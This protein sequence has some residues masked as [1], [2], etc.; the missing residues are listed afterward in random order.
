MI[1]IMTGEDEL[2]KYDNLQ[3]RN[4]QTL[5][6]ISQLQTQEQDLYDKL[7]D[8]TLNTEQKQQIVNTINQIS[9]MR[10]NI[11]ANLKDMYANYQQNVSESRSTLNQEIA[12]IDILENELKQSRQRLKLLEDEKYNKLRLVEINTYYGKRYNSHIKI[13]KIIILT[14]I[15]IIIMSILSNKGILPLNLT[16]FF[17]GIV[18][19]IGLV[20]LGLELIDISNR[21]NMNWDEYNWNFDASKA[22]SV[23]TIST[24]GTS[25]SV[26][27]PW[28]TPSVVCVGSACCYN[29]ST[30]D[31]KTNMCIPNSG[32]QNN[33]ETFT[34][35]EKYGYT[36]N[37]PTSYNYNVVPA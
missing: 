23:S 27:D 30:Y 31:N 13:M 25:S 21:D 22:P 35:L 1:Y 29:G 19:V 2:K 5:H 16:V 11:F 36:Q 37:N 17:T 14:C 6:N 28:T 12:A 3:E 34:A 20:I 10:L 4:D 32:S 24:T 8:N 9:E 18:I 33:I 7:N 26:S 15:P